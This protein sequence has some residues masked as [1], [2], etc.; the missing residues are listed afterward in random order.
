MWHMSV[1]R[2]RDNEFDI[3][4][5]GFE[6]TPLV[7][8]QLRHSPP[9]DRYQSETSVL[10]GVAATSSARP[11]WWVRSLRAEQFAPEDLRAGR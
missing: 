1:T 8:S 2:N 3:R 10:R 9:S 11:R 5:C 6:H 7:S 4:F